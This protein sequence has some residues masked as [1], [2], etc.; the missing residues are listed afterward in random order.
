MALVLSAADYFPHAG[1]GVAVFRR[2]HG[3]ACLPHS[4]PFHEVI[5]VLR[6]Q[7][8]HVVDGFTH[9]FSAG[10]VIL[11]R[12]GQTHHYRQ[13]CGLEMV[14]VLLFPS[15]EHTSALEACFPC[16]VN[17]A[18][19]PGYMSLSVPHFSRAMQ[20]V[21]AI[22]LS[23]ATANGDVASLLAFIA[24]HGVQHRARR[25]EGFKLKERRVS[26]TCDFMETHFLEQVRLEE[27]AAVA[28][29]PSR[30]LLRFFQDVTSRS[31]FVYLH[32]LRL[33]HAMLQLRHSRKDVTEVAF[34]VGFSDLSFFIRKFKAL[35]G[36]PP[37]VWRQ[38]QSNEW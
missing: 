26:P 1:N 6:G 31:P 28:E 35:T 17:G 38:Q 32:G 5:L 13:V 30:T 36:V 16:G 24:R 9:V 11:V 19:Y 34:D 20:G 33:H 23:D 22:E 2:R 7:A 21:C 4:H 27:L 10:D 14:H 8:V 18:A 25:I 15:W 29:L 3:I 37:T 12:A